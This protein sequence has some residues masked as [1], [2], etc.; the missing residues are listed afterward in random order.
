MAT[1]QVKT[2]R[3]TAPAARSSP[4]AKTVGKPKAAPA[5]LKL[6]TTK[7]AKKETTAT[8]APKPASMTGPLP[9]I[10][11]LK[12]LAEWAGYNHGIPKKQAFEMFAGFVA[13]IGQVLKKGSK[14][15]IPNLGILQIRIRPARPA[16][17]G[18]NPATGEEIRIKASKA[19]K[20]VAFR[21]A[22][23]LSEAI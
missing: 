10:V 21:V 16:R 15:R 11:T 23:G 5:V 19:S 13:D 2:M 4:A 14:I 22:K 8:S 17:K 7:A 20:K 9:P 3:N 18:R 6:V 12:H 1:P